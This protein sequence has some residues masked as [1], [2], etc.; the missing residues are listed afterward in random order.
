M[1]LMD[2]FAVPLRLD[3][4]Y[5]FIERSD[6]YGHVAPASME[7]TIRKNEKKDGG[8]RG[9]SQINGR[10]IYLVK[11]QIYAPAKNGADSMFNLSPL[12]KGEG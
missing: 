12:S 11:K 3:N 8:R 2:L 7:R 9:T 1:L 6:K 5:L 10:H 4:Q